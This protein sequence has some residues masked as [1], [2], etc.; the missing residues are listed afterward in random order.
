MKLVVLPLSVPGSER[1]TQLFAEISSLARNIPD[2]E[3]RAFVLSAM[4]LATGRFIN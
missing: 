2:E 1:K 4:T 3:Q